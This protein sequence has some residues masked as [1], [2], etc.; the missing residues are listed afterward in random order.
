MHSEWCQAQVKWVEY[1][2]LHWQLRKMW[3]KFLFPIHTCIV[4]CTYASIFRIPKFKRMLNRI[5]TLHLFVVSAI[6][7]IERLVLVLFYNCPQLLFDGF[8]DDFLWMSLYKY[9][10]LSDFSGSKFSSKIPLFGDG[11]YHCCIFSHSSIYAHNVL[12][13]LQFNYAY[14]FQTEHC[15]LCLHSNCSNSHSTIWNQ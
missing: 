7:S 5:L 12:S 15:S 2:F 3:N 11:C 4:Y 9:T 14:N 6:V 8:L 10:P 1:F 13:N